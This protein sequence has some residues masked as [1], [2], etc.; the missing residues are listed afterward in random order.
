MRAV[1]LVATLAVL[2][3]PLAAHADVLKLFVEGQGGGVLGKRLAGDSANSDAAFFEKAPHGAYGACVG[4]QFLVFDVE[5][6]HHQFTNGSRLATWTQFGAGVRFE[7]DVGDPSKE[8]KKAG[9][10]SYAEVGAGLFFG[11]GTG[12]QVMPPLSNSQIS[13]KG[14]G[15]QGRL[16][17]GKHLSKIFDIGVQFPV[18]W[19]YFLKNGNGAVANDL[20]THYQSV[21]GEA[22]LVLRGNIRLF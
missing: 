2:S 3:S 9:K 14:F 12:Q 20:S 18:S 11:L 21:Q 22:L 8:D 5:I 10:G 17:F 7:V 15:L 1:P 19:G 4:A 13:D 6:Q 16:G